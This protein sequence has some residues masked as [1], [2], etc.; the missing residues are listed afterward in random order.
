MFPFAIG[1]TFNVLYH[2]LDG[3]RDQMA[4][5]NGENQCNRDDDQE[6]KEE[7]SER[8]VQIL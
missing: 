4:Q 7:A 3:C 5:K 2:S 8:L 6:D 1:D